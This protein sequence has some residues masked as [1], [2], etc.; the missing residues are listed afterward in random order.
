MSK[1]SIVAIIKAKKDSAE[2]VK[3][4][5]SKLVA[6]TRKEDGCIEY[7]LHRDNDVP[8]VFAF[9]ETW[10]SSA[11]LE[12]HLKSEHYRKCSNAIEGMVEE[13]SVHQLTHIA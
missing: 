4:E 2:C 9:C 10:E 8:E 11:H 1:L 12:N 7:N 13:K 3:S 5:L 6:P